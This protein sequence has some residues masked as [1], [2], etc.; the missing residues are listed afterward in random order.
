MKPRALKSLLGWPMA[1]AGLLVPGAPAQESP[2]PAPTAAAA[3][4]KPAA[5]RPKPANPNK[6]VSKEI[7][8]PLPINEIARLVSIPQT[9]LA[10]ELLSKLAAAKI[11]RIDEDHIQMEAMNLDLFQPDGKTDFHIIV[12]TSVFNLK[13]RVIHSDFPVTIR[14]NDFEL[15]GEK[16]EFDTVERT[17]KLIGKVQMRVHNLKQVAGQTN[18]AKPNP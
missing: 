5:K 11:T 13:T 9:G 3:D 8:F 4:A 14:T 12:P 7:P 15:T 2:S 17:G 16:M 10:G 6:N 1:A 18:E